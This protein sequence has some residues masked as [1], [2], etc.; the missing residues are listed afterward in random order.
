MFL[1]KIFNVSL[2]FLFK[3]VITR[4]GDRK[5]HVFV[6]S[7]HRPGK[8]LFF[9][10]HIE[11]VLS[12]ATV[13]HIN[14]CQSYLA[15]ELKAYSPSPVVFCAITEEVCCS[16]GWHQGQL[17]TRASGCQDVC[18]VSVKWKQKVRA[19]IWRLHSLCYYAAYS[20]RQ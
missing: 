13:L 6:P 11:W 15:D 3:A 16:P 19:C 2:C 4:K 20:V 9:F 5:G 1:C 17:S 12:L 10:S 7:I 14:C 8:Q 18:W